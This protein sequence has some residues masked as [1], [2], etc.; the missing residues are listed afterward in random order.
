MRLRNFQGSWDISRYFHIFNLHGRCHSTD[1]EVMDL[2][3]LYLGWRVS[4]K[5]S[6]A[7][8][9]KTYKDRI[10]KDREAQNGND[11]LY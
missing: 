4:P 7:I 10:R 1:A 2:R 3:Q 8:S 9:G 5:F 11:R 6:G